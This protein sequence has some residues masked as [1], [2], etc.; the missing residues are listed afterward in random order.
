MSNTEQKSNLSNTNTCYSNLVC[1]GAHGLVKPIH[2]PQ[3]SEVYPVLLRDIQ[4]HPYTYPPEWNVGVK[5]SQLNCNGYK[6][7]KQTCVNNNRLKY[8]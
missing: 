7:L 6:T 2:V 8:N 5:N 1:Y 4:H 3:P